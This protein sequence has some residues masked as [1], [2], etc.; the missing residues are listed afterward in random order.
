LNGK[1][2]NPLKLDDLLIKEVAWFAAHPNREFYLRRWLPSEGSYMFYRG[3]PSE[4]PEYL[5]PFIITRRGGFH[6]GVYLAE[7]VNVI[8]C[9]KNENMLRG[10]YLAHIGWLLT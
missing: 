6:I 7:D 4:Q 3:A 10:L 9:E 2:G 1:G 5:L 8:E